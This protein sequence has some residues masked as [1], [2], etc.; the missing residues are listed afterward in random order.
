MAEV[1]QVIVPAARGLNLPVHCQGQSDTA[2][3][4]SA[5]IFPGAVPAELSSVSDCE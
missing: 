2:V 4:L 3:V 5:L 1:V